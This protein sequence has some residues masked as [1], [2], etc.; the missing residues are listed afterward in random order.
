M[1]R[2]KFLSELQY[3]MCRYKLLSELCIK[4][5]LLWLQNILSNPD[6]E[7]FWKVRLGN[8][9]QDIVQNLLSE[10]GLISKICHTFPS[11]NNFLNYALFSDNVRHDHLKI[12]FWTLPYF[13]TMSGMTHRSQDTVW[14]FFSELCLISRLCQA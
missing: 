10:F 1:H 6:R 7:A 14:K 11:G 8:S 12:N 3:S 5:L 2:Y 4:L 9:A 13:Q